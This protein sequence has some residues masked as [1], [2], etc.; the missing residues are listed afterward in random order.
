MES[1]DLL[2]DGLVNNTKTLHELEKDIYMVELAIYKKSLDSLKEKKC[3]E[4]D[5][6]LKNHIRL[7]K[8]NESNYDKEIKA[9]KEKYNFEINRFLQA[10]SDFY[11]QV[12]KLMADA[13][14]EQKYTITHLLNIKNSVLESN[15]TVKDGEEI[16]KELIAIAEKKLNY[17][18]II[19]E[20]R[21]R[22]KWLI[23][24]SQNDFEQLFSIAD[25]DIEKYDKTFS[26]KIRTIFSNLFFGKN[27][28]KKFIYEFNT[29][30]LKKLKS[31]T[32][33]N[34]IEL[35]IVLDGVQKQVK[36]AN[37]QI[38]KKYNEKVAM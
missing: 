12:F 25:L 20:C 24:K 38:A 17:T 6:Y 32:K 7:F 21:A 27:N 34:I 28:C 29:S 5:N 19:E 18:I 37:E 14:N 10:Y 33:K 31:N 11:I 15:G 16:R 35:F 4:L 13:S 8:Q 30:Y 22:I 1:K 23:E 36:M 26:S 2:Y 3:D 9:I